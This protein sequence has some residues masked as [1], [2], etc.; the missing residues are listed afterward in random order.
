MLLNWPGDEQSGILTV[1]AADYPCRASYSAEKLQQVAAIEE[2]TPP[3]VDEH[4]ADE[5]GSTNR[6][7]SVLMAE[8][9]AIVE[10]EGILRNRQSG[11]CKRPSAV[12]IGQTSSALS[13]NA[14]E[15]AASSQTANSNLTSAPSISITGILQT[16]RRGLLRDMSRT[17]LALRNCKS[18]DASCRWTMQGL[19]G[20]NLR[21]NRRY[22]G[23]LDGLQHGR[24]VDSHASVMLERADNRQ[25][26]NVFI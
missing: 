5:S 18:M 9:G 13:P 4:E 12:S 7:N 26:S 11:H 24:T 3:E 16:V 25:T 22:R 2:S 15:N 21:A 6:T 23:H 8:V 19:L 14:V 17:G 10:Q 1:L 20:Q